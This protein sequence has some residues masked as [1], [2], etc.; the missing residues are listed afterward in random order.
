MNIGAPV[1]GGGGGGGRRGGGGG[2]IWNHYWW[3]SLLRNVGENKIINIICWT[4]YMCSECEKLTFGFS[5]VFLEGGHMI[6]QNMSV[7]TI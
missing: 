6:G 3:H 5:I 4:A 2:R 7:V 1:G